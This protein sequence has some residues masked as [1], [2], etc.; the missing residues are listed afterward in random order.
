MEQAQDD[1]ERCT[2]DRS[3]E[4]KIA[5]DMDDTLAGTVKHVFRMY[6]KPMPQTWQ[7]PGISHE[8]FIRDVRITWEKHWGELAPLEPGQPRIMRELCGIGIVDI[9]TVGLAGPK[10]EWLKMHG[11]EHDEV[12]TV[13]AGHDKAKLDYDVFIDDSPVNFQAIREA[14]KTCILFDA[15]YNRDVDAEFRI[16]SLAEAVPLVRGFA[17]K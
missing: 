17:S 13:L 9:V 14:G 12:V 15:T 11:L 3:A 7:M 8:K 5:V 4:F 1:L 6:R 10:G 16:M 2:P